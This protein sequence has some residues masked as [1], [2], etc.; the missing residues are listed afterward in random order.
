MINLFNVKIA[1]IVLDLSSN[2][3][4]KFKR[5]LCF[6]SESILLMDFSQLGKRLL[7][8]WDKNILD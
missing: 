7:V 2:K 4:A 5:H 8:P 6:L 1:I 3:L